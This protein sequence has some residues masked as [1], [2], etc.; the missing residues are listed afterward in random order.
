[1]GGRLESPVY[2]SSGGLYLPALR[3]KREEYVRFLGAFTA[4][5][6]EEKAVADFDEDAVTMAREAVRAALEADSTGTGG[7]PIRPVSGIY[8]AS[9][10]L[11]YAEKVQ[12]ATVAEALSPGGDLFVSEHTTSTRAGTEAL[13]CAARQV[14]LEGGRVVAAA[15][16]CPRASPFEPG[17]HALGAGAVALVLARQGWA[18]L[19]GWFSCARDYLGVRFRGP[20]SA[21]PQDLGLGAYGQR[22]VQGAVT[23]AVR[24]L[25]GLLGVDLDWFK[26][27]ILP[28][29]DGRTPLQMARG[30][31]ARQEQV[32]PALT[33]PRWGD[34][35]CAGPL[36]SL[37]AVA[38]ALGPGDRVLVVSWGSGRVADAIALEVTS[39]PVVADLSPDARYIGFGEYSRR[40]AG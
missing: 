22:A 30:L 12:A 17:E 15:A 39:P 33:V 26:L 2:V 10:T 8:L 20:G 11:P 29:N 34:L 5:G 40:R 9:T 28:Q 37:V 32:S 19:V 1:M 36:A 25:T 7:M 35:G 6:V 4:P 27:V 31:G 14:A 38:P 16:E 13:I 3:I 21:A 23:E 24:G 18:R